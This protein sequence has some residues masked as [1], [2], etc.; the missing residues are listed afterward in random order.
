[1]P[2]FKKPIFVK[3]SPD[4]RNHILRI[5]NSQGWFAVSLRYRDEWLTSIC[6]KL[7]KQ[8]YLTRDR[9]IHSGQYIYYPVD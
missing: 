4:A 1:M 3:G 6:D 2:V 7:V 5:A 8:G 9:K